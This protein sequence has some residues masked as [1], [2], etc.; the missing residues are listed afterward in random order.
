MPDS[1]FDTV[2]FSPPRPIKKFIYWCG[3]DFITEPIEELY[4]EPIERYGILK[5]FGEETVVQ[6]SN[7]FG[8]VKTIDVKTTKLQKRQDRGGQSQNRIARLRLETIHNY[9][10][11]AAEKAT[12]AFVSEGVPNVNAILVV[13]SGLKKEQILEYLNIKVP[14]YVKTINLTEDY[15]NYIFE[16]IA[17]VGK[18]KETREL[19]EVLELMAKTPDLLLFGDEVNDDTV[20]KKYTGK[21]V[22]GRFG[23]VVGV[24]YYV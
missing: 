17:E 7:E 4:K 20:K 16:M 15:S 6:I 10:K 8:E 3:K 14:I 21:L 19:N 22:L 1:V 11:S 9:L 5:V 13:G 12:A 24:K 2:V 23:G 18:N